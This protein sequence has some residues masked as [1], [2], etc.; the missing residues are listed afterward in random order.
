MN[1]A[2]RPGERR[3][4]LRAARRH[5][6]GYRRPTALIL[7]DLNGPL[8]DPG[9]QKDKLQA[10]VRLT[11]ANTLADDF[12]PFAALLEA[13]GGTVPET[14]PPFPDVLGCSESPAAP[15]APRDGK[16]I[17]LSANRVRA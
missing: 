3:E 13:L 1:R 6:S 14:M 12:R 4:R 15:T 2:E 5:A 9:Q 8:L 16:P 10:A 17:V 11:M 7:F